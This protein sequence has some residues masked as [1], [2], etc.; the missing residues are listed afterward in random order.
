VV[1][2]TAPRTHPLDGPLVL[3]LLGLLIPIFWWSALAPYD[4]LTW[5]LEVAPVLMGLVA[6]GAT[7]RGFPLTRL[8]YVLVFLHMV[9]LLV[10]GHYTYARVPPFDWLRDAFDL[11]RN[12]YDRLGHLA[13]GFVPAIIAREILL[14]RGVLARP[15]WVGFLVVCVCLAISACYEFIEW[16]AA[17]LTGAGATEFLATQGDVWD[18]QTDM[19]LAM[20]GA[21]LA[22]VL[23]ARWHDREMARLVRAGHR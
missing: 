19:F 1:S 2:V 15:G 11:S 8:A 4:R 20:I 10:G 5:W 21:L 23:L 18:T 7:Y 17:L 6:L 16:W 9:I 14:R 3:A 12:H 22:L 13:Q